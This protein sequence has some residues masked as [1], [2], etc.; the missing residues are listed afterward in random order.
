MTYHRVWT[1]VVRGGDPFAISVPLN[2]TLDHD[3][4]MTVWKLVATADKAR[5][6]EEA[7]REIGSN[8]TVYT[9]ETTPEQD[10][11]RLNPSD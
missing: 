3:G 10:Q 6:V 2:P 11:E 1:F 8:V 4:S 5:E 9:E 7:I